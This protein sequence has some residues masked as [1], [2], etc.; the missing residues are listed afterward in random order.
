MHYRVSNI[1]YSYIY[2]QSIRAIGQVECSA[3]LHYRII[4]CHIKGSTFYNI[5][6]PF[7]YCCDATWDYYSKDSLSIRLAS[8]SSFSIVI[9]MVVYLWFQEKRLWRR[10]IYLWI[11]Y[12]LYEELE[13][14]D[15]EKTRDVYKAC[16]DILPHKKFTF[17]KIWL[18]FAHFEIRQKNLVN[19]RKVMVWKFC[20]LTYFF[21]YMSQCLHFHDEVFCP[22]QIIYLDFPP[23]LQNTT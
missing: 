21:V 8:V 10:Y 16:L 19:A 17:A 22:W 2:I 3:L 5:L 6:L 12:A 11:N 4:H 14:E 1:H 23:V 18:L 15:E 13:T 9:P 7:C 20:L